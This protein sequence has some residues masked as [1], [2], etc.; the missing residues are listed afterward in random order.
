MIQAKALDGVAMSGKRC[1]PVE[2]RGMMS[3]D[4]LLWYIA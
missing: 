4:P 1:V 3:G 2:M